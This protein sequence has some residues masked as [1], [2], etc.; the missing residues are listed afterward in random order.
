MNITELLK[1]GGLATELVE[2]DTEIHIASVVP[3]TEVTSKKSRTSAP[4]KTTRKN[5]EFEDA[6]SFVRTQS[7]G[8]MREYYEWHEHNKPKMLPKYPHR[9]Y[10]QEWVSWNDFLGNDNAPVNDP[11]Q[12]NDRTKGYKNRYRTY[13]E[14]TIFVHR[15]QLRTMSEWNEWCQLGNCPDDIPKRPDIVYDMWMGWQAWLGTDIKAAANTM[16]TVRTSTA[17]F[18]VMQS[19]EPGTPVN[20]FQFVQEPGGMSA[21]ADRVKRGGVRL[22]RA[23]KY[24]NNANGAIKEVLDHLSTPWYGVSNMRVCPNIHSI[25]WEISAFLDDIKHDNRH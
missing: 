20:V 3:E 8:S 13:D 6:R 17:V 23:F 1:Q 7:I 18:C 22:V 15:L 12:R 10:A 9:A 14:A 24:D 25:I 21:I 4:R 11:S 19:T 2:V 16:T 5:L